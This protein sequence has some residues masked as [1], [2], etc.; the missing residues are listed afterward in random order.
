M[1]L[2]ER[3]KFKVRILEVMKITMQCSSWWKANIYR[4]I[5]LTGLLRLLR[6]I[7]WVARLRS[8]WSLPCLSSN[9][10]LHVFSCYYQ[11]PPEKWK[12][13]E[14]GLRRTNVKIFCLLFTIFP[15]WRH[16]IP[17]K[18]INGI[19]TTSKTFTARI[20]WNWLSRGQAINLCSAD[21]N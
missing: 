11:K 15:S 9:V 12:S 10:N 2:I 6:Q 20:K 8:S 17:E 3:P 14:E 19:I 5:H 1:K 13:H 18:E 7:Q 21:W 4:F 16:F